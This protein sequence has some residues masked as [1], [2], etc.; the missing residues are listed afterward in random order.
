MP[1]TPKVLVKVSTNE[2]RPCPLCN[3]HLDGTETSKF[4]LA[5]NHLL[6]HGLKVLHVGTETIDGHD[7]NPWH[8]TVA[9]F[10]PKT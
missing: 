10:G 1:A 8:S 4:E 9:V 7:G 5:C 3:E 2:G 6:E